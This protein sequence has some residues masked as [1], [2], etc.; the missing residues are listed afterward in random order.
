MANLKRILD[1]YDVIKNRLPKTFP[2]A[3]LSFH[4]NESCMLINTD[5]C[6]ETDEA[7]VFA[8]A[9]ADTNTISIPLKL[10]IEIKN[11][12]TGEI[13]DKQVSFT[14]QLTDDEIANIL[15][16]ELGHLYAANKYGKNSSQFND[17]T[18]ANSF[19]N[20]WVKIL[21]KEKLL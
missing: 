10:T 2:K 11:K 15:C 6:K 9:N 16:H 5:T 12:K 1:L 14:Q 8:V 7:T 13:L 18:Y 20:R 3:L 4:E 21:K 17:E 19:A